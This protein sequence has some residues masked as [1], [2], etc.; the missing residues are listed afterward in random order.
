MP[1][2]S[3]E[4]AF[5]FRITHRANIPWIAANGLHCMNSNVRD[6]RFVS[7]GHA[8]I[9][10][11]RRHWPVPLSPHGTL[12]DYVPFYFTSHSPM[13]YNI[14]TG[15]RVKQV[16]NSDI[17]ILC[18]SLHELQK[19]AI[20]FLFTDGHA[21]MTG[22][23]FYDDLLKLSQIDWPLLQSRNFKRDLD[24]LGKFSRY[25]AE[26][27]VHKHLPCDALKGIAC[28]ND[29][30]ANSVRADLEQ[31]GVTTPVTAWPRWYF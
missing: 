3:P 31:R 29:S 8:D 7:I 19:R 14:K 2:L 28:Y 22:T 18:A 23:T 17:V 4:N 26:A 30:V 12:S 20:P 27:L 6:P 9:I 10:E 21:L 24:D 11:A 16:A 13:A 25:E 15:F 1:D 5:I